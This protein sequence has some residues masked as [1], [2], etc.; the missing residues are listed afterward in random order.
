MF[1]ASPSND[2]VRK[3]GITHPVSQRRRLSSQPVG[4]AQLRF[5]GAR[6]EPGRL[7][8]E[9]QLAVVHCNVVSISL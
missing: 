3:E 9:P 8:P 5:G 7:A 4:F 2:S 6:D 1:S